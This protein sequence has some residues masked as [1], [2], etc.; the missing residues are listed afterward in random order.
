MMQCKDIPDAPVLRFLAKVAAGETF[1]T[2]TPEM[3]RGWGAAPRPHVNATWYCGEYTPENS[4]AHAMPEGTPEKL[5]LAKMR[6]MIR[7]GVVDGCP[8]GCRGDFEITAKGR[9]E[10]S[11]HHP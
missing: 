7:R 11:V 4:V 2:P 6:Q 10:L 9:K 3:K 1:W 8:C 5:V